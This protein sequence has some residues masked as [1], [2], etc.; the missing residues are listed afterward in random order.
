[1][2]RIFR[3][4]TVIVLGI[5]LAGQ[6]FAKSADDANNTQIESIRA[7]FIQAEN[8]SD[9]AGL[10]QQMREDALIQYKDTP[11]VIGPEGIGSF[12]EMLHARFTVESNYSR[13]TI[14]VES[15]S[16]LEEGRV[17]F[18]TINRETGDAT[19][20]TNRYQLKYG[21]DESGKWL[22]I[23][24]IFG[25]L[26]LRLPE[27]FKPTG[28]YSIGLRNYY[29]V[30]EDRPELLTDNL[31]D[32]REIGFQ[33]WYPSSVDENAQPNPY[34]SHDVNLAAAKF[35]GFPLFFNS[36]QSLL[37]T[38]S[39]LNTPVET[40]ETTFP[41][42]FYNHGY[43]GFTSVHQMLC[44]DIASHG[45]VVVSVGHAYET[46]L[47]IKSDGSLRLFD[48]EN[49]VL[50]S[51]NNEAGGDPSEGAKDRI[52]NATTF[53][54]R[55]AAFEELC[56]VSPLHQE[57]TQEW[58]KDNLSVLE[59]IT[60][61]NQEEYIFNGRLELNRVGVLGH[62]LGGAVAGQLVSESE[63][64]DA[65][66]DMDG[67]QFGTLLDHPLEKPFM[68]IGADRPWVGRTS[69]SNDIFFDDSHAECHMVSLTGYVHSSFSD[70]V[71]FGEVWNPGYDQE[72]L[73]EKVSSLNKSVL[74]FFD[75]HLKNDLSSQF[76]LDKSK[77]RYWNNGTN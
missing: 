20:D 15:N 9:V 17:I 72:L 13:E 34:G 62:S 27:M 11:P 5:I 32:F 50:T 2:F 52:L 68:Y 22:L 39:Y 18:L 46:S 8:A 55:K 31:D 49:L 71:L 3:L 60:E 35:Y 47:F 66:I 77:A 37:N 10:L 65:G 36:Y 73:L 57:S 40:A 64:F 44:E 1:M 25:E 74:F 21:Q 63:R 6:D 53:D 4:V 75:R 61:L 56:R 42:I 29:F 58:A 48:R 41:V 38:H 16:A 76:P 30:D 12:L 45:Y 67:F 70:L 43:S 54:E 69:I 24:L 7:T 19:S 28:E 23:S 33:V 14:N 26:D 59:Y 51:R